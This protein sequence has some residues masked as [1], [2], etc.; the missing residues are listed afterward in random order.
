VSAFNGSRFANP[1]RTD[2]L[3]LGSCQCPGTPHEQDEYVHR[4]ELGAG[5]EQRAGDYG[6]AEGGYSTFLG[7]AAQN[8]LI[9]IAGIRWN[10]LDSEGEPMPLTAHAA[11]LLDEDTRT[12]ILERIDS[13]TT[14]KPLPKVSAAPSRRSSLANGSGTRKTPKRR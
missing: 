10:L 8:R 1:N 12:L 7:S 11:S 6:W 3:S 9:E 2:V 14:R 13:I 4:V 5:E